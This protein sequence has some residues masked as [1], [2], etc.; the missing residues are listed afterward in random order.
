MRRPSI[1]SLVSDEHLETP[2]P[3]EEALPGR[4]KLDLSKCRLFREAARNRPPPADLVLPGLSAGTVGIIAGAGASSKSML[5]LQAAISVAA[6]AD[7]FSLF[8]GAEIKP[9]RAVYL[10]FEDRDDALWRRQHDIAAAIEVGVRTGLMLNASLKGQP[11]DVVASRI[12]EIFE[13]IEGNLHVVDLYGQGLM[14]AE[15]AGSLILP[16]SDLDQLAPVI[17]GARVVFAD[18]LNKTASPAGLKEN[19][20]AD[21][22]GLLTAAEALCAKVGCSF[23]FLHHTNKNGWADA[24]SES[25]TTEMVR[26]STVLVYNPRW[27]MLMGVMTEG[28]AKPR[29]GGAWETHHRSWVRYDVPKQNDGDPTKAAWLHRGIGGVLDGFSEPP[30]KPI[31]HRATSRRTLPDRGIVSAAVAAVATKSG[32]FRRAKI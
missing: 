12:E 18:T 9:G 28:Q 3:E 20:S 1:M 25:L 21:M 31:R 23:V 32:G 14:I 29:F 13:R 2:V 7:L 6:G 26:G 11:Q 15:R 16:S 30:P 17:E 4:R 24:G 8:G 27:V 5:A 19:D 10:S 22:G